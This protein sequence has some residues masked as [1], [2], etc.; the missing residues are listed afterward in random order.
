MA[1]TI[2]VPVTEKVGGFFI[3]RTQIGGWDLWEGTWKAWS[4][5][6][7]SYEYKESYDEAR[8]WVLEQL[9]VKK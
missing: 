8:K 4:S 9:G 3:G 7:H 5:G 2:M 1:N 6:Y